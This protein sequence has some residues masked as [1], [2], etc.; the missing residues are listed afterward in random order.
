[1]ISIPWFVLLTAAFNKTQPFLET[2]YST[3]LICLYMISMGAW[4]IVKNTD[5]WKCK[6][7]ATQGMDKLHKFQLLEMV[8]M[9]P[10]SFISV[11][12][13]FD[14]LIPIELFYTCLVVAVFGRQFVNWRWER[15]MH[16]L[17]LA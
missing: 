12:L 9:L 10:T 2:T 3:V 6:L 17:T 13:L 1:M 5:E 11:Y 16:Q 14:S 7:E 4:W 8:V 15:Q